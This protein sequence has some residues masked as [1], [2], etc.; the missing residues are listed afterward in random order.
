MIT[1][2]GMRIFFIFP[3]LQA[4][5]HPDEDHSVVGLEDIRIRRSVVDAAE[6]RMKPSFS[7]IFETTAGDGDGD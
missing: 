5:L 7:T 4:F 1:S 2:S 6:C 3:S